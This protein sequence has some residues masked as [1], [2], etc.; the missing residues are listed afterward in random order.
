MAENPMAPLPER[1]FF[2][3]PRLSAF[4]R[5]PYADGMTGRFEII[6]A[7][8]PWHEILPIL[9]SICTVDKFIAASLSMNSQS[10][11]SIM[12]FEANIILA[13]AMDN[14]RVMYAAQ[15][16]VYEPLPEEMEAVLAYVVPLIEHIGEDIEAKEAAKPSVPGTVYYHGL[17]SI[18]QNEVSNPAS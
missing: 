18:T 1:P 11:W 2:W 3:D 16:E 17:G 9:K 6:T 13:V 7:P 12:Y 8:T 5:Q 10:S 14:S 15:A 4:V